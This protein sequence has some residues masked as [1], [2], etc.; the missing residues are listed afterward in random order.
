MSSAQA[1]YSTRNIVEQGGACG[2]LWAPTVLMPRQGARYGGITIIALPLLIS[3]LQFV[4][5]A[6]LTL[7]AQAQGFPLSE[8]THRED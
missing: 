8:S 6:C 3:F 5:L 2:A 1:R 7:R 4:M